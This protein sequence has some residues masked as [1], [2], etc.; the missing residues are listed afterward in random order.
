MSNSTSLQFKN[1]DSILSLESEMI[2]RFRKIPFGNSKAATDDA[3]IV[4]EEMPHRAYRHLGLRFFSRLRD[5][6]MCSLERQSQEIQLQ[7][8]QKKLDNDL[9]LD[10]LDK[11]S[12][13]IEMQKIT[14]G[15][16]YENMLAEQCIEEL[17]HLL[18]RIEQLP[19]YTQDEFEELDKYWIAHRTS[20]NLTPQLLLDME[21]QKFIETHQEQKLLL[22]DLYFNGDNHI[23]ITKKGNNV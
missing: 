12:V 9:F 1:I 13:E 20:K 6:K 10:E 4:S 2:E 16:N 21:S 15:W 3:Q 18:T 5:L 8:L 22:G 11:A 14:S 19:K 23:T 17:K 7:R